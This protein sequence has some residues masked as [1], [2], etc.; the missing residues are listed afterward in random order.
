MSASDDYKKAL[1]QELE[2][3]FGGDFKFCKSKL[4]LKRKRNNGFDIIVISGS[5]KWSPHINISFYFGR[6]FDAVRKI[7]KMLSSYLVPCHIQQYSLNGCKLK[8]LEYKGE[9]TWVVNIEDPPKD[10][11]LTL[12]HTIE[13]IAFPFFDRFSS[14]EAAQE[15]LANDD[16]WCFSPKGP[17]YHSLLLV[18]DALNYLHHFKEWSKC[19]E[20]CYLQKANEDI[21]KLENMQIQM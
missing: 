13:S 18:D 9:G 17:L 20:N 14:L 12:K 1:G 6:N 11:A 2:K 19:L 3:L 16:S 10:M 8:S 7:E 5:S 21:K 4:E 15:A